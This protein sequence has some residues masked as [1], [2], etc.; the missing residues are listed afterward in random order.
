MNPA[1]SAWKGARDSFRAMRMTADAIEDGAQDAALAVL[2]ALAK[3]IDVRNPRAFG[4]RAAKC[5]Q[6]DEKAKLARWHSF[7]D[8]M[9]WTL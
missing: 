1:I 2:E 8:G 9:G 5:N 4:V 7:A 3:G 6:K